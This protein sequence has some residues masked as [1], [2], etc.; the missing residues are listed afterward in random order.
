VFKESHQVEIAV[1]IKLLNKKQRKNREGEVKK[2]EENGIAVVSRAL[3]SA[4]ENN[5]VWENQMPNRWA[6]IEIMQDA[7]T[8]SALDLLSNLL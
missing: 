7:K 6:G 4:L 1:A 5:L 2:P 8:N 3:A